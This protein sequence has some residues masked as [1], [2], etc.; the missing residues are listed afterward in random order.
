MPMFGYEYFLTGTALK[1]FSFQQ[2]K[3][4]LKTVFWPAA[5]CN[6][7][8]LFYDVIFCINNTIV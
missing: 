4:N 6:S 3:A 2:G 8:A 7:M 5:L 1:V